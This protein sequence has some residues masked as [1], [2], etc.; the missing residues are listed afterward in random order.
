MPATCRRPAGPPQPRRDPHVQRAALVH[1]RCV[2]SLQGLPRQERLRI[3]RQRQHGAHARQ[4]PIRPRA[5]QP[6]HRVAAERMTQQPK[7]GEIDSPPPV[8]I[9]TQCRQQASQVVGA[10]AIGVGRPGLRLAQRLFRPVE[11]RGAPTVTHRIAM[12]RRKHQ[13]ARIGERPRDEARLRGAAV[14][15]M[16]EQQ[17]RPRRGDVLGRLPHCHI[18]TRK[19]DGKF[20]CQGR[21]PRSRSAT[22][23]G[24]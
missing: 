5:G 17:D 4:P 7:P 23:A 8:R 18:K 9:V 2:Q 12:V 16:R 3:G 10:V 11:H 19:P 1:H 15:P 6:Q 21:R 14:E 22:A 24:R 20:R 13:V